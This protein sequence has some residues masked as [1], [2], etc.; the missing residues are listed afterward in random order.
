MCTVY[1]IFKQGIAVCSYKLRLGGLAP[2]AVPSFG[3][4]VHK[5][6]FYVE[7]AKNCHG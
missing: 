1:P 5:S 4:M 2:Q 7:A 6:N 3:E